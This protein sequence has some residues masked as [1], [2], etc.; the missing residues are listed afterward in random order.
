MDLIF[1]LVYLSVHL[2]LLQLPIISVI[3]PAASHPTPPLDRN[4]LAFTPKGLKST[5]KR[6]SQGSQNFLSSGRRFG[7]PWVSP[8]N[9]V[10]KR[11]KPPTVTPGATSTLSASSPLLFSSVGFR[12]PFPLPLPMQPSTYNPLRILCSAKPQSLA[13]RRY[14]SPP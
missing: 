12:M 7:S 8:I 9:A 5:T 10:L 6:Y 4:Y 14:S 2:T 1:A 13:M 11:L 3:A